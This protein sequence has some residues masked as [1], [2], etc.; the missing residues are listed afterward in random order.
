MEKLGPTGQRVGR[1]LKELRH[2]RGYTLGELEAKLAAL[3]RPILLS[4]LSKIEKG[5]RR[6]DADDLVGLAR[7]LDVSPNS[8]MLPSPYGPDTEVALTESTTMDVAAAWSWAVR[9]RPPPSSARG[10]FISY[11]HSDRAWATWVAWC[12]ENAGYEVGFDLWDLAPNEDVQAYVADRV[13]Q[14]ACVVAIV[15]ENFERSTWTSFELGLAIN[16]ELAVLQVSVDGRT[17]DSGVSA[18]RQL[19]RLNIGTEADAKS[20]LLNAVHRLRIRSKPAGEKPAFPSESTPRTS[21]FTSLAPQ[22][23]IIVACDIEGSTTR[24]STARAAIREDMYALFETALLECGIT[25]D[26]RDPFYDRGDGLMM[27]LPPVDEVP[28]T[29]L[30]RT[31][32]PALAVALE[33]HAANHPERRFR[34][35]VAIHSGDVHFDQRG[36]FGEDIDLAFRLLDAPVVKHRLQQADAPLVLVVSDHIHRSVVRHGYDGIDAHTFGP[37]VTL[38]FAGQRHS[39]WVQVPA[40]RTSR[41]LIEG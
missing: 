18:E 13:S 8:L 14:A 1:R 30:L 15:S 22:Q 5:Q 41:P 33:E 26:L 11:S 35:R 27:L 32:V 4:A 19:V 36:T 40:H 34:L 20:R 9:D 24:I 2:E 31:F 28:K 12:L 23:R 10:I 29:L 38:E 17:L 16:K 37:L 7:A 25:E 39:G 21:G 3:G 6:V